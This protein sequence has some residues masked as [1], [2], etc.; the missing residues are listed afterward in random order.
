LNYAWKVNKFDLT[1]RFMALIVIKINAKFFS[2]SLSPNI[3]IG[4]I[5]RFREFVSTRKPD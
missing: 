2:K 1:Y 5:I 4:F 3:W